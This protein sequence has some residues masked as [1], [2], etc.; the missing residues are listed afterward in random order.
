MKNHNSAAR[1]AAWTL[2][3]LMI[4]I[5]AA[6]VLCGGMITGSI[7]LLKSYAASKHHIVAQSEQMR[8]TDF[9]N[10]DLRRALTVSTAGGRLTITIP[11]YYDSDHE[12]R[13]PTIRGSMAVYGPTPKQII[14]QKTGSTIYRQEGTTLTPLATDVSDFALTFLDLGQSIQV[15][16]TFV[17][18]FQFSSG[19]RDSSRDGTATFT[20]TLLRNKRQT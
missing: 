2:T 15:T 20:T 3:E 5:A 18:R 13:T 7:A 16:V 8:L 14:Y 17:P 10:L 12:P 9:M 4:G 1:L 19:R 6:S 11:D